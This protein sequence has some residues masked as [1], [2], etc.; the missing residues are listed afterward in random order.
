MSQIDYIRMSGA[1]NI[2]TIIDVRKEKYEFFKK[3]IKEIANQDQT[4]CDQLIL[5]HPSLR[6][7][8]MI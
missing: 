3:Q 2:F 4:K 8:C 5:I 7:D 6:A 1:G